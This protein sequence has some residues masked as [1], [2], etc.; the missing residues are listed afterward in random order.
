VA[1]TRLRGIIRYLNHV[2]DLA[3]QAGYPKGPYVGRLDNATCQDFLSIDSYYS[4]HK[5][6]L[7]LG[8]P[9]A[10]GWGLAG[11]MDKRRLLTR[12]SRSTDASNEYAISL[13]IF[14][15]AVAGILRL[16]RQCKNCRRLFVGKKGLPKYCSDSCREKA[17]RSTPEGKSARAAYMR[18]YRRRHPDAR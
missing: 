7:G 16:I 4:R 1:K 6:E 10:S 3:R 5:Y 18:A 9:Q 11:V 15:A 17:F 8:F 13:V 14:Q 12:S 2:D